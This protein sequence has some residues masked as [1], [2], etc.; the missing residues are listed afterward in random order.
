MSQL[1]ASYRSMLFHFIGWSILSTKNLQVCTQVHIHMLCDHN[2]YV[3]KCVY[4]LNFFS[5]MSS[6]SVIWFLKQSAR[7][8]VCE[9]RLFLIISIFAI[10][11]ELISTSLFKLFSTPYFYLRSFT[12]ILML[13]YCFSSFYELLLCFCQSNCLGGEIITSLKQCKLLESISIYKHF[14]PVWFLFLNSQNRKQ[15]KTHYKTCFELKNCF[16]RIILENGLFSERIKNNMFLETL[17]YF[18]FRKNNTIGNIL[19]S[20]FFCSLKRIF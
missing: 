13:I 3:R 2:K 1:P 6:V 18:Q 4:K 15:C 12:L 8:I 9:A 19:F 17:L 11:L 14:G 5:M 20:D 10:D 16:Q 7:F